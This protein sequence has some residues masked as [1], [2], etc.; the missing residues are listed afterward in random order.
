MQDTDV[1]KIQR[2]KLKVFDTWEYVMVDTNLQYPHYE[3]SYARKKVYLDKDLNDEDIKKII[4]KSVKEIC[5]VNYG[6]GREDPF[7]EWLDKNAEIEIQQ[8]GKE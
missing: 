5:H 2:F 6:G 3:I 8:I 1:T 7:I 4:F